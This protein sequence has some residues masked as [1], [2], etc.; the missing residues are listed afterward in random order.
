MNELSFSVISMLGLLLELY[1][2]AAAE[3]FRVLQ[4]KLMYYDIYHIVM[5]G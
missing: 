1:C 2:G 4:P 5:W 3:V